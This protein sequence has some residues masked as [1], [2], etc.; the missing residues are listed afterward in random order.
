MHPY[1]W[2]SWFRTSSHLSDMSVELT[3]LNHCKTCLISA[4][5][6]PRRLKSPTTLR[7]QKCNTFV[8]FPKVSDLKIFELSLEDKSGKQGI[9]WKKN[10]LILMRVENSILN[11]E[12]NFLIQWKELIRHWTYVNS[13]RYKYRIYLILCL[14]LALFRY[15]NSILGT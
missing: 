9:D 3:S 11:A 1:R 8:Y 14:R 2:N 4:K 7:E 12:Y 10:Q 15:I 5:V 13:L 6:Q